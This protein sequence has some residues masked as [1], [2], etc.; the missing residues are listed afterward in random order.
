MYLS[1][2]DFKLAQD[3]PAKL[4]YRKRRYP[5][6]QEDNEYLAMLAEGGFMV[7]KMARL[8]QANAVE[9][10]YDPSNPG[11]AFEGTMQ[12]LRAE[13]ATL[14]EA[15]LISGGKLARVD[16]L[17]KRGNVFDLVE[18]KAKSYSSEEDGEA[19]RR[20]CKN[21]F[22]TKKGRIE[23][24]W[25]DYLEDVTFQ[26]MVLKELFPGS[27]VRPFLLMPDKAKT[28]T[29][30]GLYSLFNLSCGTS[31]DGRY[32][33]CQVEF[34]GD[35]DELR[36]EH[37][38]AEITVAEEVVYLEKMVAG[39]AGRYAASLVPSLTKMV[40]PI[41]TRCAGCEYRKCDDAGRSGF[42]ECWG[43]L[44]GK[45]P[46]LL[47]LYYAGSTGA[48]NGLS[49]NSLIEQGRAGLFDLPE[50]SFLKADGTMGSRGKRQ[51]IQVSR[52][53][54]HAE[55][56]DENLKRMLDACEYPLHFIDFETT[57][58]AI[59]YHAGMHPYEPIAFQWSCHTIRAPGARP[60]HKE[61]INVADLFPNREFAESLRKTIG[62]AGTVFKYAAHESTILKAIRRQAD[63]R[64]FGNAALNRW[65]DEMSADD[66]IHDLYRDVVNFYFHPLMKGKVSIKRTLD[67]IWRTNPAIREEFPEYLPRSGGDLVSPYETLPPILING[68][69]VVVSEGT[70]AM[71][72]YEAMMFGEESRDPLVKEQYKRLLLQYCKLDT[73]AMVML[74]RHWTR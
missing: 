60:E 50:E 17:R 74:W 33:T 47:D 38:L 32:K 29:I 43:E 35:I 64:G 7:E 71:R 30:E 57:S 55:W 46:H 36:R 5:S 67:A 65:L 41:S 23:P 58:L 44:A 21:L 28:T 52:T 66:R 18:V 14:C 12:A 56:Q 62:T 9:L 72:A 53:R 16:I 37:F 34:E 42:S 25:R 3:C 54:A 15:T 59:P 22:W 19:K 26:V 51:S 70:G 24:E 49:A 68:Q 2:S 11:K 45:D 63:D 73:A 1:K 13:R 31:P 40:A 10:D 27:K 4:Y 8:L 69:E 20:G 48:Y 61:W 6:Y 39:K